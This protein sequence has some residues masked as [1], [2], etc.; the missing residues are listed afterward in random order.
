M[1]FSKFGEH[2]VMKSE[3]YFYWQLLCLQKTK[4]VPLFNFKVFFS[5]KTFVT[6]LFW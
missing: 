4:Y 6:T 1:K 2:T 5:S 3:K